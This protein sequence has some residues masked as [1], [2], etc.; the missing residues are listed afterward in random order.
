MFVGSIPAELRSIVAE[1]IGAWKPTDLYVGCS[2]NFTIERAAW[3]VTPGIRLH[4]NDV[5][6][7]TS[8]L[9]AYFAGQPV[10]LAVKPESMDKLDWLAPYF[11][12]GAGSVATLMLATRFL[13]AVDKAAAGNAYFQRMVNAYRTQFPKLYADTLAKVEAVQMRLASFAVRDVRAWLQDVPTDAAVMSFPPFYTGG[14]SKLYEGLDRHLIWPAPSFD[15]MTRD[16]VLALIDAYTQHRHWMLGLPEPF[17]G[18][19][20]FH[21]G[22][23]QTSVRNIPIYVYSDSGARRVVYPRQNTAP[24]TVPRLTDDDELAGPLTLAVLRQPQFNALRSQYMSRKI[25]PAAATLAIAVRSAG[26]IVGVFAVNPPRF[27]PDCAY[28]LSDFAVAPTRYKHLAKLVLVA[29]MS[30]E[31]HMLIERA[32]S[33]RIRQMATTAF[34]DNPV[35]M[36]YRGLMTLDSRKD[37]TTGEHKFMLNY[38]APTRRWSLADGFAMWQQRWGQTR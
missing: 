21:S 16:D 35:S 29:A 18:L 8:T 6:I 33:R 15:E 32:L 28:L 25:Q 36:K 31:A 1:H 24:V 34:T 11:D 23:V 7:Y 12:Q 9:G 14:Y 37:A 27:A 26:K 3:D 5:S 17:P 19:A 38:S 10:E 4:G 22:I 30:N 20:E 2:G 13:D